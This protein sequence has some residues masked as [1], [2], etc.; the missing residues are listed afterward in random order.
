MEQKW[1]EN[2]KKYVARYKKE[3]MKRVP[4]DMPIHEYEEMK[5]YVTARGETVNGFIKRLVREAMEKGE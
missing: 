1:K 2:K 5:A 4:L 3:N